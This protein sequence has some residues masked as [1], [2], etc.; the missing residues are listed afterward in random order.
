MKQ[1]DFFGLIS[2]S[3]SFPLV[4]E[5]NNINA[6]TDSQATYSLPCTPFFAP[7]TVLFAFLLSGFF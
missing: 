2:V 4:R 6:N 3:F 5:T 1:I 7:N